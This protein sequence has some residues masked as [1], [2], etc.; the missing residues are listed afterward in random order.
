[1]PIAIR[2]VV[3]HAV[4][5]EQIPLFALADLA[6][7]GIMLNTA[8][9]A[10][11]TNNKNANSELTTG[12]V[13]I[14][15]THIVFL[16]TIYCIALFPMVAQTFIWVFAVFVL[17]SSFL[18]S[19]CTISKEFLSDVEYGLDLANAKD[20]IRPSILSFVNYLEAKRKKGEVPEFSD[21][22]KF[23]TEAAGYS[24]DPNT[25]TV[26]KTSPS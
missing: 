25:M 21:E 18:F 20:E 22:M 1:M 14:A 13:T 11:V 5:N 9:I 7:W 16:V 2:F 19:A 23:L 26:T 12:V 4:T 24:Y 17:L 8:A 6:F 3:G 10:N 15:L